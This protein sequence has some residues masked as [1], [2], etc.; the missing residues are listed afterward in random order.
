MTLLAPVCSSF[1]AI[2]QGTHQRSPLLP[3][4]DVGKRSVRMGN[5]LMSRA[6][7]LACLAECLEGIWMLEQPGSSRIT[8]YPRFEW[9]RDKSMRM[10]RV[11]WW[12]RHYGSLT[13]KRHRAWGNTKML[14]LLDRGRLSKADMQRC[15][16]QT[17]TKK[18]KA[19]GSRYYCGNKFL[20]GT[21]HLEIDMSRFHNLSGLTLLPLVFESYGT[22]LY[23]PP[24][25]SLRKR[26]KS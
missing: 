10:F 6:L 16:V 18:V 17:S 3:F 12:G 9:L 7:L 14:G 21:Q 11:A 19:D 15:M 20:K 2:N 24:I 4:G 5:C 8:L 26:M 13:P 1:T 25:A 22:W 23:S